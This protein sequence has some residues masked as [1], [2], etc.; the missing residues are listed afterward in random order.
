MLMVMR[1]QRGRGRIG[2]ALIRV[3][4]AIPG[5]G[6]PS[7]VR[8]SGGGEVLLFLHYTSSIKNL[9]QEENEPEE[10]TPEYGS[11]MGSRQG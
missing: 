9:G 10:E 3:C 8:G 4:R 1:K 2:L 7:E 11:H 6:G 5:R